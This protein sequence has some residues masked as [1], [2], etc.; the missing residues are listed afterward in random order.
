MWYLILGL[1]STIYLLINLVLP[2]IL[3]GFLGAYVAR[4]ILFILLA[5]TVFLIAKHEGL[6]IFNFKKIRRWEI[7]K[8][9]FQAALLI[10][11]FQ[12]SLM[13]IAG[14]FFGF[15]ESPY[16]F[17]AFAILTNIIF[18]FST[19]IGIELARAYL[20]K[21][22]TSNKRKITL[23]IALVTLFF[24]LITIPPSDFTVLNFSDPVVTI[25]F[26]GETIIPLF[27]MSLF[28]S[29]LAYLGGALAAIGYMGILQAFQWFS[30]ALPDL[31]WAVAALIGTLAPAIGFVI[32][33]NSIQLMQKTPSGGRERR[34]KKDPALSWT[35]VATICVLLIFFSTGFLGVQPTIIYSGSMRDSI[36]V[37]DIVI[38]SE[39][40]IDEI[41]EGD[42]IQFKHDNKSV[43]IIH[44]VH[45]IYENEGNK[46]FVTKGDANDDPDR[47][48]VMPG[49]IMGKA[50]F[51]IPKVGWI[52]IAIKSIVSK[53]GFNI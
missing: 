17:T 7:G 47:E 44:R 22:G 49:Q 2:S 24:M 18:V 15:G 20:V 23:T 41:Y 3:G 37:G 30:P 29:Y 8:N 21:K 6:N 11:G 33:Q 46:M 52:P 31:D 14:L 4:P 10:A 36:D 9:P 43:P 27:A 48:P 26:I 12:I 45:D 42:I 19:L 38:V 51:N 34:K 28:A 1:L 40:P 50:I 53:F 39:V 16:A 5:I 25:K 13:V 35:A 32:I